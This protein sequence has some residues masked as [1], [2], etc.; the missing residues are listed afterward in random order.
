MWS[1]LHGNYCLAVSIPQSLQRKADLVL[2]GALTGGAALMTEGTF[3][4]TNA[5]QWTALIGGAV[6]VVIAC[7][8]LYRMITVWKE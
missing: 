6:G 3:W 8:R 4:P 1:V 5:V 2:A 7:V